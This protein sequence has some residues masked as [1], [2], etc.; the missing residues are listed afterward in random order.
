M[1]NQNSKAN[2]RHFVGQR[3]LQMTD[4]HRLKESGEII[5]KIIE[6]PEWQ[7]AKRILLYSPTQF[8]ADI[9][10]LTKD[11]SK[12]FYIPK[13]THPHLELYRIKSD[14]DLRETNW[15]IKEPITSRCELL[16]DLSLIDLALIPG[17]AFDPQ[18]NRLGRGKGH[19][20]RLLSQYEVKRAYKIGITFRE[21]LVDK[22]EI[23]HWDI[24]MDK[25]IT[26]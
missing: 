7:K 15:K 2:L 24:P 21:Q 16:Y 23:E 10:P 6:L 13:I 1:S 9:W 26:G 3:L 8:E 18:G 17:I 20:D 25:V 12:E 14:A 22:I 4:E 5:Q 19:Y 11:Q